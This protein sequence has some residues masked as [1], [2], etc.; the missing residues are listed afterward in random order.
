MSRRLI[1]HIRGAR[2]S[3]TLSEDERARMRALLAEY[4]AWKPVRSAPI[5]PAAGFFERTRRPFAALAGAFATLLLV[6]GGVSYAAEGALPGDLLYGVKVG[7]TESLMTA[8]TP[9]GDAQADWQIEI[10]ERRLHEAAELAHAGRLST[11]TEAALAARAAD[12][13]LKGAAEASLDLGLPANAEH[14]SAA[15]TTGSLVEASALVTHGRAKLKK[16]DGQG[17]AADLRA[18]LEVTARI[19]ARAQDEDA[20]EPRGEGLG[21]ER[22]QG[23]GEDGGDASREAPPANADPEERAGRA[24]TSAALEIGL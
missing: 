16:H 24:T 22:G 9:A 13:T 1:R 17:A 20:H 11:S 19:G 14:T 8:L 7:V 12:A 15:S 4:A 6:T 2:A 18:A 23:R 21:G 5:P 10:A 3:D